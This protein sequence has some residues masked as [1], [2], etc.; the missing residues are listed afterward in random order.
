MRKKNEKGVEKTG[1]TWVLLVGWK[2]FHKNDGFF[3]NVVHKLLVFFPHL[4]DPK[5][6]PRMGFFFHLST[7]PINYYY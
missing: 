4:V 7:A 5:V 6:L 3:H 1:T 2:V